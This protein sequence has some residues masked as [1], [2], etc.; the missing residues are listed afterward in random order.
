MKKTISIF[1]AILMAAGIFTACKNNENKQD[2]TESEVTT[3]VN[4]TKKLTDTSV[5]TENK[6]D[7]PKIM[8]R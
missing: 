5:E 3:E 4:T 8:V 7:H 6:I 2:I 1:L